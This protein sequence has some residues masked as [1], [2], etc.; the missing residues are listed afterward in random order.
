MTATGV[1]P[2]YSYKVSTPDGTMFVHIME[3]H[4]QPIMVLINIGK[5]G[6]NLA[7]W[8]DA[9]ARLVSRL[10]PNAGIYGVIEELS[11][12]TSQGLSRLTKG[13]SIRSGPEGVGYCLL[14][15][16]QEKFNRD[17]PKRRSGGASTEE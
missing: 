3:E 6:T 4:D 8:A 7:A 11:G 13:E 9:T 2:T 10:L 17:K 1:F 12:I 15:Y 14:K 5:S 16:R